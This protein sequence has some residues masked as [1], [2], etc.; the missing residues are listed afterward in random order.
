MVEHISLDWLHTIEGPWNHNF[1]HRPDDQVFWRSWLSTDSQPKVECSKDVLLAGHSFGG[2]TLVSTV[3]LAPHP[4]SSGRPAQL[5]VLSQAPPT[6]DDAPLPPIPF[7]R[8]IALDP[9]LEPL[10]TP[11]PAPHA[12]PAARL[13]V[14]NS[15][16]FTLWAEHFA[17]LQGVV[18]AWGAGAR[19][20]T[21]VRAKHVSF[22][23]LGVVVPFG[24]M[25]RDGRRVLDVVGAL[26]EAFLGDA[27]E[28]GLERQTRVDGKVEEAEGKKGG[29]ARRL[30]GDVGDVVVHQ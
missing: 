18:R 3:Q 16:G 13:L 8:A 20:L 1:V 11:G 5:S 9:W 26:A 24:A 6:L 14:L 21:L 15:E 19:L 23:D 7:T 27:F 10:P 2:A 28:E 17:R 12:L 25:A 22:S 29:W 30:V 4:H